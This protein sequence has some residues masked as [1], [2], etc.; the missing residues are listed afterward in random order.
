MEKQ[1]LSKRIKELRISENLSQEKLA[2][3]SKLSLRTIQRI[4]KGEVKPTSDSISRLSSALNCQLTK[5]TDEHSKE[6]IQLLRF[7]YL[8][9]AMLIIN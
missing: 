8:S 7:V 3:L 2:E 6:N 5:V 4:E 1:I 9:S